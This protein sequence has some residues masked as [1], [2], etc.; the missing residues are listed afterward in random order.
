MYYLASATTSLV[1]SSVKSALTVDHPPTIG[2]ADLTSGV[3][4]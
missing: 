3:M 1:N 2:S 4:T